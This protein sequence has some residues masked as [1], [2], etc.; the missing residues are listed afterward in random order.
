MKYTQQDELLPALL[1][2]LLVFIGPGLVYKSFQSYKEIGISIS[3]SLSDK[4]LKP[5]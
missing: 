3:S 1:I 5:L 4:F 2:G